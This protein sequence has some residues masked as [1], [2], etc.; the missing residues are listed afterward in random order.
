VT[1]VGDRLYAALAPLAYDDQSQGQSLQTL[2]TGIGQLFE[3]LSQIVTPGPNGEPPWSALVDVNRCPGFALPW[4]GQ[5]AGV[6]VEQTLDE[7]GQRQQIR[8]ETGRARGTPAAIAAAAQRYLTGTKTVIM[9][10]R[11]ASVAPAD[12]AY[13]LRVLTRTDETPDTAPVLAALTAAKPAG[14]ILD[15]ATIS[16]QTWQELIDNNATW[17]DVISTYSTW[18]DVIENTP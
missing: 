18:Q 3:Q 15:Y 10:E 14:I 8:A 5:L 9:I 7:A 16:G 17:A 1:I 12:P 6:T 11:D 2:S 13:G 4:L